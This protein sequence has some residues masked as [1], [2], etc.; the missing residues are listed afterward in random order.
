MGWATF[1]LAVVTLISVII[2]F[3]TSSRNLGE[4]K[5]Q[6]K[7]MESQAKTMQGQLDLLIKPRVDFYLGRAEAERRA[8]VYTTSTPWYVVV[9]NAKGGGPAHHVRV[10][11]NNTTRQTD[12]SSEFPLLDSDKE[13]EAGLPAGTQHGDKLS[14]TI[15]Y[16]DNSDR[17]YEIGETRDYP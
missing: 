3:Y 17:D 13:K 2:A 10:V 4:M 14:I 5:E 11:V 6:R 15:K 16:K 1:T 12:G 8:A 7:V 9:R